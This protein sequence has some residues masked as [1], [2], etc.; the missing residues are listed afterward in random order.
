MHVRFRTLI[1]CAAWVAACGPANPTSESEGPQPYRGGE[2]H[3]YKGDDPGALPTGAHWRH[4][5]RQAGASYIAL[6][7]RDFDLGPGG[8]LRVS[9]PQGGQAYELTGKG[10]M[11]AGTFWSQHVKG[12][13]AVLEMHAPNA[14]RK[15]P[16]VIDGYVGGARPPV[17]EAICGADDKRAAACYKDSHPTE[18]ARGRAV[19]R[20]LSHGDGFCTGWLVGPDNLLITNNHC[21]STP[22]AARDTDFEMNGETA[23]CGEPTAAP[24][25]IFS[26]GEMLMTDAVLDFT[27]IRVNGNPAAEFGYLEIDNRKAEVGEEIYILGHPGGR[28]KEFTIASSHG[29]DTGGVARVYSLT[30]PPCMGPGYNDVGYYGDTEGGNSGSPVLARKSNKVIALHHCADCPNRGVP[31]DLVHAKIADYLVTSKGAVSTSVAQAACGAAVDVLLRDR[32]LADGA[33]QTVTLQTTT[34]DT[35]T[36]TL[37]AQG[38]GVFRGRLQLAAADAVA[39]DGTVQVQHGARVDLAYADANVGDGTPGTATAS[40]A[41]DCQAPAIAEVAAAPRAFSASV[42]ARTDEAATLTVR[43]GASCDALSATATGTA[44]TAHAVTLTGLRPGTAYA[45]S[46]AATDAAGN[47]SSDDTCR[48]FTTETA[49]D[50]FFTEEFT[51]APDLANSSLLFVPAATPNRYTACKSSIAALPTD[52]AAATVLTLGDDDSVEIT[53]TKPV[54]IY[55]RALASLFVG[56]NGYVSAARDTGWSP[57]ARAHFAQARVAPLFDDLSPQRGGRVSWQELEDRVA[58][59]WAD[60]P[61]YRGEGKSTFQAELFFDGRIRMSWLGVAPDHA[62]VGVSEGAGVPEGYASSDLSAA[63]ACAP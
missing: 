59:T 37:A 41:V 61:P 60:V 30:E 40:L 17:A 35:E 7:F 49:P 48:A 16:F 23:V 21:I 11:A 19:A 45:F 54:S 38:G 57:S 55:G 44:G 62:L 15:P 24:S 28:L 2:H 8:V 27:L 32:D 51:A 47:A 18:Y 29:S 4:E 34:G 1:G 53:P 63:A 26:G 6:H 36:V 58:I 10:K 12:E 22:E 50:T 20:L 33:P 42:S 3:D 13:A 43:F 39:G 46:V 14:P 56:S 31:I 52:A 25:K 9:D 5:V